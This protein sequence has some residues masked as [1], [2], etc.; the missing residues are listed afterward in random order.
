MIITERIHTSLGHNEPTKKD[1]LLPKNKTHMLV[2][3]RAILPHRNLVKDLCARGEDAPRATF[4][5]FLGVSAQNEQ[6][7]TDGMLRLFTLMHFP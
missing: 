6:M 5:R 7:Y 4:L 1:I 2:L 3:Y